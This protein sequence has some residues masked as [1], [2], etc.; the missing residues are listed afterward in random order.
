MPC[1]YVFK[2]GAS[3]GTQCLRKS[4]MGG[5]YCTIHMARV[6]E[7]QR[8]PTEIMR[9]I[10]DNVKDHGAKQTFARLCALAGT[11]KEF[12]EI[13]NERCKTLYQELNLEP[14]NDLL[15]EAAGMPYKRRL[16]LLLESGCMR[17]G[18]PRITKIHWP[19]PIRVCKACIYE[20]TVPDYVL[21]NRYKLMNYEGERWIACTGW[22]RFIGEMSYRS[23]LVSD[24][25]RD[26]GMKL[27]RLETT[28]GARRE[29]HL[30]SI[31][32]HVGVSVKE[33]GES[34]NLSHNGG[35]PD[36]EETI[37]AFFRSRA[38][39][40]LGERGYE[41]PFFPREYNSA[42]LIKNRHDYQEFLNMLN[43]ED[44]QPQIQERLAAQMT[45]QNYWHALRD[46]EKQ[47]EIIL[48]NNPYYSNTGA[49]TALPQLYRRGDDDT[50]EALHQNLPDLMDALHAFMNAN[51]L[52]LPFEHPIAL[53]IARNLIKYPAREVRASLFLSQWYSNLKIK[54]PIQKE[55]N[56]WDELVLL[57][58]AWPK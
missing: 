8:F 2:R 4:C 46:V 58:N 30:A 53:R 47:I 40:A 3:R 12:R 42:G 1:E 33:L 24:V 5:K 29:A 17:C 36:V 9:C 10:A 54:H 15:L 18:A 45:R 25:E 32:A 7:V 38:T 43:G 39:K 50:I 35:F 21:K 23:F 22:N 52:V 55:I 13:V 28:I 16:H 19:F 11:C 31:A 57:I 27:S 34:C 41:R 6:L 56:T 48:H 20:L 26:V 37:H 44:D 51:Q 14:A 49:R